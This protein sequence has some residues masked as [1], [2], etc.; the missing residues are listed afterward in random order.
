MKVGD[1]MSVGDW[2]SGEQQMAL[3]SDAVTAGA[4]EQ[5]NSKIDSYRRNYMSHNIYL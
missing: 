1:S 5:V 3:M 2:G 4:C